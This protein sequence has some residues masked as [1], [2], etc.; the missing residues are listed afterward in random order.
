MWI[1]RA[2]VNIKRLTC[3]FFSSASSTSR[4]AAPPALTDPFLPL[5]SACL[6]CLPAS[7]H[8]RYAHQSAALA[9]RYSIHPSTCKPQTLTDSSSD[10]LVCFEGKSLLCPVFLIACIQRC[11]Y[12]TWSCCRFLPVFCPRCKIVS[13]WVSLHGNERGFT[14]PS[15]PLHQS[16]LNQQLQSL[17]LFRGTEGGV[18]AA[19]RR[20]GSIFPGPCAS[21]PP[22][23]SQMSTWCMRMHWL[24]LVLPRLLCN[25]SRVVLLLL[26][27]VWFVPGAQAGELP[28]E[29]EEE[30]W[31]LKKEAGPWPGGMEPSQSLK[32]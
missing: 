17:S 7:H 13:Y 21:I 10:R 1:L 25:S 22:P 24:H 9:A 23:T 2:Y 6:L 16:Q 4:P 15:L 18:K 30:L 19:G 32:F 3:L 14:Q 27:G 5:S 28:R 20:G 8:R 12:L 31:V 11:L 26:F 29:T